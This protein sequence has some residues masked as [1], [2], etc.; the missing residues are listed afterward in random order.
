MSTMQGKE[1]NTA[2]LENCNS[3]ELRSHVWFVLNT[4]NIQNMPQT[5]AEKLESMESSEKYETE[6]ANKRVN[7]FRTAILVNLAKLKSRDHKAQAEVMG[8]DELTHDE[9]VKLAILQNEGNIKLSILRKNFARREAK[10]LQSSVNRL[11]KVSPTQKAEFEE[12]LRATQEKAIQNV[13]S[14]DESDEDSE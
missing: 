7:S 4:K 2:Q 1:L 9:L 6:F 13:E 12:L 8:L 3:A 5:I 11:A 14:Y 10:L